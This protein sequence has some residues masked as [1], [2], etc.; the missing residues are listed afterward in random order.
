MSIDMSDI[1]I[2]T[3]SFIKWNIPYLYSQRCV[4]KNSQMRVNIKNSM[5]SSNLHSKGESSVIPIVVPNSKKWEHNPFLPVPGDLFQ[6]HRSILTSF[7]KFYVCLILKYVIAETS[8]LWTECA[9][10]VF[11]FYWRWRGMWWSM[12][13]PF[14]NLEM[15]FILLAFVI[16]S[17]F[18]A[19]S[20]YTNP[21]E[22]NEGK[23]ESSSW[24]VSISFLLPVIFLC[25]LYGLNWFSMWEW[26]CFRVMRVCVWREEKMFAH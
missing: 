19:A 11:G 5:L 10:P 1:N 22:R 17:L 21:D 2:T 13:L 7:Y 3:S 26:V 6:V 8:S 25:G 12:E 15:A 4:P 9:K 16:F 23:R 24:L 18:T 14:T 20:I